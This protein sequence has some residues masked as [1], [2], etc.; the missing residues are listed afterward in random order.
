MK[1]VGAAWLLGSTLASCGPTAAPAQERA[2]AAPTKTVEAPTKTEVAPTKDIEAPTRTDVAPTKSD[3]APTKVVEAAPVVPDAAA[4]LEPAAVPA[5]AAGCIAPK[6]PQGATLADLLDV[7]RA[8]CGVLLVSR[9]DG[10]HALTPDLQPIAQ[11]TGTRA[12]WVQARRDAHEL[13]FFAAD[14]PDLVRFD[15]ATRKE[16]VLVKL[17]RLKHPCFTGAEPGEKS[18]PADPVDHIQTASDLDLDVAAGVL[19][20]DVGDRNDNMASINV[21][22][23]ADLRTGKVEQRVV[24]I[25]E[26]CE[27]GGGR[28]QKSVCE[29]RPKDL[30]SQRE[31]AG[32]EETGLV[33]PSGRWALYF[34]DKF[35]MSGDYIYTA[36]FL[37]DIRGKTS[38]AVTPAGLV[39]IDH[40]KRDAEAGPPKDTCYLPGEAVSRWLP[41]RDVLVVDGCGAEGWLIVEPP[42]TVRKIEGHAVTVYP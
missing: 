20:L 30:P 39:K 6:V 19:C 24:A 15:L 3:A 25:G 33:S 2:D 12:R 17:P 37:R 11:I 40:A 28:E 31:I 38:H 8:A 42:G 22:F 9:D 10:L 36:V 5:Q 18:A 29:P 14:A 34:D 35:Q 7:Y 41:D 32:I 21:N 1:R 16:T 4:P 13:Y 27:A 26:E 23:R